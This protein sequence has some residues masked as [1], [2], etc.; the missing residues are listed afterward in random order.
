MAKKQ[1]N[2]T[3]KAD[4]M[5]ILKEKTL[6][7]FS[8]FLD[9]TTSEQLYDNLYQYTVNFAK[10]LN[11]PMS[12]RNQTIFSCFKNRRNIYLQALK[13]NKDFLLS[14][15]N[16]DT[17]ITIPEIQLIPK[18]HEKFL[19]KENETIEQIT[20]PLKNLPTSKKDPCPKCEQF[21]IT[22]YAI[23]ERSADEGANVYFR[24]NNCPYVD[25][26]RG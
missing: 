8:E 10:R 16:D 3:K 14:K 13:E 7:S 22:S 5:D 11:T 21:T 9:E 23:Y 4:P 1:V 19:K 6:T 26:V 17:L 12:I 18:K 20:N 15:L 25:K 24:C 2:I